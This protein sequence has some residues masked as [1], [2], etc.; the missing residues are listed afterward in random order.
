MR[1]EGNYLFLQRLYID[2]LVE[3]ADRQRNFFFVVG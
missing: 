3:Q 1:A 2:I